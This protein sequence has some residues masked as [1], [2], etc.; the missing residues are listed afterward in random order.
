MTALLPRL[1][2]FGLS[3]TGSRNDADE[4]VQ[5]ACER[6]LTRGDQ[7][8]DQARMDAW[9][10]GIMRNLWI[11]E[12]RF[13]KVRRHDDLSAAAD[14]V[15]ENGEAVVEGRITLAAVRRVVAE[16]SEDRRTLLMLV[17]VDGLT[18]QEAAD[19]LGIAIGTVMSRLSR[20]RQELQERLSARET[21]GANAP[22][23]FR[24]GGR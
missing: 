4:L 3:L 5:A 18:Y 19:T 12:L 15:G 1:R 23:P 17:C 11:D 2:R 6:V 8:R 13:R 24:R 14:V 20:A 9:I 21:G 7:L 10:Y 16:M 22:I